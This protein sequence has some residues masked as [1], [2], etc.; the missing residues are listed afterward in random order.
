MIFSSAFGVGH[1]ALEDLEE[2]DGFD[3]EAGFFQ[4]FTANGVVKEFAGLDAASGERPVILKGFVA[5]LDK[6]N[7]AGIEDQSPDA[8]HRTRRILARI[9]N[10]ATLP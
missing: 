9:A 3:F 10:T 1:K 5:A 6:Q 8:E 2:V 7:S 4:D